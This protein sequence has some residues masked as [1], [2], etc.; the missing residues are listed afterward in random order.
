MLSRTQAVGLG[1][2]QAVV[3]QA[4]IECFAAVTVQP[5]RFLSR[6][7]VPP[8]APPPARRI[9]CQSREKIKLKLKLEIKLL[10]RN[11]AVGLGFLHAD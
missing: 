8:L 3:D 7:G 10:L 1:G 5:M 6:M 4:P 2:L 9:P 11:K